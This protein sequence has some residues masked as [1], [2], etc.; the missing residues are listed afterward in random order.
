M[1]EDSKTILLA[2][3]D[4]LTAALEIRFLT[5]ANFKVIHVPDGEEAIKTVKSGIDIDLIIMDMDLGAGMD[6]KAAAEVILKDYDIP[7]VFISGYTENEVIE[8]NRNI[9]YI[10]KGSDET[11]LLAGI[12]KAFKLF[13]AKMN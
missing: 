11:V 1:T 4:F 6:G 7:V 9:T 12:D 3:D 8:A 2:E 13:E 5:K 10:E